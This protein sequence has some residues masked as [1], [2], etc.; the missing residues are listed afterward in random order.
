MVRTPSSDNSGLRKGAWSPDE[1]TK[2]VAYITRY[3]HWNWSQLP[4][5]A[6]LARSGKSCRLRWMNYL[7]PNVKRGNFTPQQE[8]CIIRIHAERGNKWSAI[9]AELPG[10]TDLEVKNH[11]HTTLRKR[12]QEEALA[13]E[14]TRAS[15]SSKNKESMDLVPNCNGAAVPFS[16]TS[17]ITNSSS[18]LFS[19]SSLSSSSKEFSSGP[20]F[21]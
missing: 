17:Q 6:G 4:R 8:E 1:D 20:C 10:R 14:E 15:K 16:A 12:S 13:I 3:G 5:F 19:F 18:P 21:P 2:L 9:A 11:W 7:R